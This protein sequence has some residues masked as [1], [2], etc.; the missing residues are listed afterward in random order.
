MADSSSTNGKISS[1]GRSQKSIIKEL[2][3]YDPINAR[4]DQR[5]AHN[6]YLQMIG[7][8]NQ[9][10]QI[11]TTITDE[12]TERML[13]HIAFVL[14]EGELLKKRS[15]D[16]VFEDP[17]NM[18]ILEMVEGGKYNYENLQSVCSKYETPAGMAEHKNRAVKKHQYFK[19]RGFTEE[20]ALAT[21]FAIAF[22]TGSKGERINRAGSMLARVGNGT[23]LQKIDQDGIVDA[24]IILY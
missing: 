23:A 13:E 16:L 22:Y 3:A 24:G 19:D 21:T 1:F 9:K 14:V 15:N 11:V 8:L 4:D 17:F 10:I 6:C 12:S 20:D 18:K 7:V 2:C 5:L